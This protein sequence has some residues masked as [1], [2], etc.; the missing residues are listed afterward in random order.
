V[1]VHGT[2]IHGAQRLRDD[3]GAPAQGRPEPLAYYH[4]ASPLAEA[5]RTLRARKDGPLRVAV[6]GLGA[7]SLSCYVEPGETWR[8]FE[9]DPTVIAIARD[10]DRFAF[11]SSC[12]PGIPIV[13]GDARLTLAREPDRSYDLVIIDAYS[14]DSIPVHLATREAMA[15]YKSKLASDGAILMH[16]S[17]RYLELASVVAGI[18]AANGMQTWACNESDD[19]AR[20]DEYVFSSHVAISAATEADIGGLATT[21]C[22]ILHRPDRTERTWTDDY[23][24]ILGALWRRFD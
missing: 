12:A 16:I 3:N 6:V 15:I 19:L 13:L 11:V 18:A 8:F 9:I 4:D 7:G 22:W 20:D 14:S 10:P 17:N 5:I 21:E 24:N 2:T 23:S 1:L